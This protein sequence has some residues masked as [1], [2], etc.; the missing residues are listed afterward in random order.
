M[1]ALKRGIF[2]DDLKLMDVSPVFKKE[3]SFKKES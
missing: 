3:Y 2:P 1:T